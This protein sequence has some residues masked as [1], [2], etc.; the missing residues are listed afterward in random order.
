M[1]KN[2]SQLNL[3]RRVILKPCQTENVWLFS[4]AVD[5]GGPSS[6]SV[7]ASPVKHYAKK[8]DVPTNV[9][10]GYFYFA[11]RK[12][13]TLRAE[14]SS[15]STPGIFGVIVHLLISDPLKKLAFPLTDKAGSTIKAVTAAPY[16][17]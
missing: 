13:T 8:N 16:G 9:Q 4:V 6:V 15:T 3:K 5:D 1:V 14:A 11:R 17:S 10:H 12:S 2:Y 7:V